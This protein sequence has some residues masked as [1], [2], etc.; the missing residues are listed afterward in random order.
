MRRVGDRGT[1]AP[2]FYFFAKQCG[3]DSNGCFY[4]LEPTKNI[5]VGIFVHVPR[6]ILII[7]TEEKPYPPKFSP[8]P[9]RCC[10]LEHLRS[11]ESGFVV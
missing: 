2:T 1:F 6:E 10:V 4:Y 5:A 11:G 7:A 3:R 8:A 9:K